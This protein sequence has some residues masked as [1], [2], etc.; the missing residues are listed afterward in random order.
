MT[1]TAT[2]ILDVI[3]EPDCPACERG[4]TAQS[5]DDRHTHDGE[6]FHAEC[7]PDCEATP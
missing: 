3:H 5:W 2:P 7:C 4:W 6:D 1:D